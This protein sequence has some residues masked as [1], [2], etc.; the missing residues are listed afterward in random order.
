MTVDR[1]STVLVADGD[2]LLLP[3]DRLTLSCK[4]G[5]RAAALASPL[6]S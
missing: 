3:G 6:R 2:T 4:P 5:T 1:D